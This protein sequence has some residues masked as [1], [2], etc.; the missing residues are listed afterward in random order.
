[1]PKVSVIVPIYNAEK[2]LEECLE[3]ICKQTLHDIEILCI[4][5]GSADKSAQIIDRYAKMDT[6]I[7]PVHKENRGY[8]HTMNVGLEKA[9][10]EYIGIVE[11]DDWIQG[12]MMQT[13]YE[14]AELNQADFVKSDFYR[15]VH[16]ADGK[17]R[18]IYYHLTQEISYYNRVL[19][20][21][22][23]TMTFRFIMNI[24][25]GIY[26]RA[27]LEENRIT[28]HETPGASFQDNGF[29]FKTFAC[30]KRAFFLKSAFYM[31]RR[32][33]PLSSVHS[34]DKVYAACEEYDYIREWVLTLPQPRKR[35]LYLCAEGRLR[36]CLFTLE[37]IAD[38]FKPDFYVKIKQ[39][40][41]TLLKTG[42]VAE[43]L[44]PSAW[45][46]RF[47]KILEAP[48]K[49]CEEECAERNHYLSMLDTYQ[50]VLI[51]GAGAF[52]RRL[53]DK[54][55]ALGQKNRI[56]YFV[57]TSMDNNPAVLYDIPVVELKS[58]SREFKTHALMIVAVKEENFKDVEQNILKEG[59]QHYISVHS[60]LG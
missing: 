42:E 4:D 41:E 1:M 9:K 27:F 60:F 19:C 6:R 33:N 24:W 58:L 52:G 17:I 28:F 50:D 55:C 56:A 35:Y 18:K 7:V 40:Y 38:E 43:M 47:N 26:R 21:S 22:D 14:S 25:S 5:D 10:G 31:N 30:A 34:R 2:Y 51:Y 53:Y 3:S 44:L 13:L 23:E 32:D 36:N 11:S 59:F 29:W 57:V 54:L 45:R 15:F 37:R 8:G 20:P 48:Q 46:E 16:Q 49:V 39:D 12:E